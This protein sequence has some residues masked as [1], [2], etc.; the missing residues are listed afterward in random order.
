VNKARLALGHLEYTETNY[1]KALKRYINFLDNEDLFAEALEGIAWSYLYLGNHN[2]AEIALKR[3]V[4]QAPQA[5]SGCQALL[6]LSRNY[7]KKAQLEWQFKKD[8]IEDAKRIERFLKVI[9][10]HFAEGEI[11]SAKYVQ[12]KDRLQT[13]YKENTQD[14]GLQYREIA[15]IFRKSKESVSLLINSYRTGDF[16]NSPFQGQKED[17]LIRIRDLNFKARHHIKRKEFAKDYFTTRDEQM[18]QRNKILETVINA[19]MFKVSL[20]LEKRSWENDY[21]RHFVTSLNKQIKQMET[22][23]LMPDSIK[24]PGIKALRGKIIFFNN[25]LDSSAAAEQ[26][27]IFSVLK[28]LQASELSD[29]QEAHVL[30]YLGEMYYLR[31][32]DIYLKDDEAFD[33]KSDDYRLALAAFEAGSLKAEP[34]P[35]EPPQ[36][37]FIQAKNHF[38]T[39][40]KKYPDSEFADGALYSL[41]FCNTEEDNRK[42]AA[43][44]GEEL[45]KRFPNS[46]YAPQAYLILGEF[47][48]NDNKLQLALDRYQAILK[49]PDSRWFDKALYKMGWT[50]YR[51]SDPKKAISAFFYLINEQDELAE[52]GLDI[53][54]F[55]KSLLT[56]ESIDYI[57]ISFAEADTTDDDLSGLKKAKRFVRKVRNPYIGSKILHKLGDVYYEQLKYNNAIATFKTLK[58]TYPGYRELPGVMYSVIECFEQKGQERDFIAANAGRRLLFER[59]NHTSEWTKQMDDTAAVSIADSLAERCLIEAASYT[60]SLALEKKNKDMYR[61]VIDMYWD[62]LKA[63]PHKEKAAEC[64]YYIAEILFGTGDYLEAAKQYMEVSRRY[65]KSKYCETAAMNA[66]VAAQNLLKQEGVSKKQ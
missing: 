23:S 19:R 55:T 30:Y 5:P 57:S 53:S 13:M 61:Q 15:E 1:D 31:A 51:L 41:M 36:L 47:Y 3:L 44:Y 14:E 34:R 27:E 17:I 56:K 35:P 26:V 48:F 10:K 11:D 63:Y 42:E 32:W 50:Y 65:R 58:E 64:H 4:N 6:L 21:R 25:V 46:Q 7:L 22:D 54:L 37:D 66:I 33:K 2:K 18:R 8:Q 60:Y 29:K 9:D 24:K 20:L 12:A 45:V 62:Y 43:S 28:R 38:K 40:V 39:L 59:Y 52:D 49:Y 16:I